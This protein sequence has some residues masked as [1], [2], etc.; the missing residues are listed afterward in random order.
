[1]KYKYWFRLYE[2]WCVFW[3]R[4]KTI[5]NGSWSAIFAFQANLMRKSICW[6]SINNLH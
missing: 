6:F 4:S 5:A 1:M 2:K 3:R